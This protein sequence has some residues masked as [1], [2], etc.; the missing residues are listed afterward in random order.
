MVDLKRELGFDIRDING[1]IDRMA[2]NVVEY[3]IDE[4]LTLSTA[5]SC[6]GG[7]ISSALTSVP[8]ASKVFGCG[9]VS[10]SESIKSR[11]LGVPEKVI[12][13][14]GVVSPEVAVMMA[15]GAIRLSESDAAIAVT[16]LAGP[17]SESDTLPVGT[18][19]LSAIYKDRKSVENL[20][21]YELGEFDRRENRLLTVYF[22]LSRLYGII[23]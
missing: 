20:R 13:E 16:G 8:G 14:K 10:Y 15:E 7:M 22:A 1:H 19:Y 11:L 17:K 3:M 5:E 4:K 9:I 18:V 21:L 12:L 6:T 2:R 23:R